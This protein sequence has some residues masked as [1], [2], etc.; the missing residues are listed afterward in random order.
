MT[1]KELQIIMERSK[2]E[3]DLENLEKLNKIRKEIYEYN[4]DIG[5]YDIAGMNY[6]EFLKAMNEYSYEDQMKLAYAFF[7]HIK[8]LDNMVFDE[9]AK[10][11]NIRG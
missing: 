5:F 3:V 2:K 4:R 11:E 8:T 1:I 9:E 10:N 7:Q 6:D